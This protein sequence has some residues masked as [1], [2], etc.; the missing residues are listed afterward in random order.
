MVSLSDLHL[1][2][3]NDEGH[4]MIHQLQQRAEA[5]AEAVCLLVR[6]LTTEPANIFVDRAFATW[7]SPPTT[8]VSL[9]P[10]K[11]LRPL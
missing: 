5:W 7:S 10:V 9:L 1:L 2:P 4:A 8:T 3:N 6:A 11:K